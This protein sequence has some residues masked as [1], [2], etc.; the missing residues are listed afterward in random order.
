[1]RPASHVLAHGLKVKVLTQVAQ[2]PPHDPLAQPVRGGHIAALGH[3]PNRASIDAEDFRH[4]A[5][6]DHR[7]IA[8]PTLPQQPNRLVHTPHRHQLNLHPPR[9][10]HLPLALGHNHPREP[11]PGRLR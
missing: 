8:L 5:D 4:L 2:P 6:V 7:N 1:M 9:H 3:P 10:H 11:Q